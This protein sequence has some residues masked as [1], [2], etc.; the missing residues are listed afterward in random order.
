MF[1]FS[2]SFFFFFNVC[3]P[4]HYCF[5]VRG[6]DNAMALQRNV[7]YTVTRWVDGP[8]NGGWMLLIRAGAGHLSN[9]CCCCFGFVYS[10]CVRK[11]GVLFSVFIQLYWRK[12]GVAQKSPADVKTVRYCFVTCVLYFLMKKKKKLLSS[13]PF[14]RHVLCEATLKAVGT[15]QRPFSS[16]FLVRPADVCK[17]HQSSAST[18]SSFKWL[19]AY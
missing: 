4:I 13:P 14:F 7:V 12:G 1:A 16:C 17:K 3:H 11:I 15:T 6:R 2:I 18:L 10:V 19:S 8:M 9:H 5:G